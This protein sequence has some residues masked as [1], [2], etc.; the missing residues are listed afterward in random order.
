MVQ[1]YT[2]LH[3]AT[4][5]ISR[6]TRTNKCMYVC[7]HVRAMYRCYLRVLGQCSSRAVTSDWRDRNF[8]A[9]LSALLLLRVSGLQ[10]Y[11]AE[12]TIAD[13]Q[14]G[15]FG[16]HEFHWLNQSMAIGQFGVHP[17]AVT[18]FKLGCLLG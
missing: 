13:L 10:C 6:G 18:H 16:C 17:S 9:S 3:V 15:G 5:R 11:Q 14:F 8:P 2:T 4:A 12:R 7:I 1:F